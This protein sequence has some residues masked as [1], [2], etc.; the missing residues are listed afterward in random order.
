MRIAFF[1]RDLPSEKHG[2]V[3]CQVHA[4]A[5]ALCRKGH[6]LT[7]FSL[8][9]RPADALYDVRSVPMPE[10]W[11]RSRFCRK[12]FLGYYFAKTDVSGFDVVHA[13]G[14]NFLMFR[15]S[16]QVRT[17]YGSALAEA[18]SAR[19]PGRAVSQAAL[20]ALEILGA[21]VAGTTAAISPGTK[22]YIP[23]IRNVV[24][25]GVDCSRYTPGTEKSERPSVLFVGALKGRKRGAWLLAR[26]AEVR[27]ALPAAELWMVTPEPTGGEGVR[28]FRALPEDGLIAL[29]QRAWVLCAPSRYEGFGLPLLE[30]MACGTPVLASGNDGSRFV[31]G[32]GEYGRLAPDRGLVSALLELLSDPAQRRTWIDK[33][34]ARAQAFEIARV[35][36][37]YLELYHAALAQ[38]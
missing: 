34:L 10:K 18:L 27:R 28:H 29:Y 9:P 36:D 31:L 22:K 6:A 5:N 38:R 17:F 12:F 37:R 8:S 33:G 14:D 3:A 20:W 4:L 32:D 21:T 2:G 1:Q 23:F 26:F 11:R 25:C 16:P 7:V 30:A 15:H 35:A 24:P 13:H 19:S